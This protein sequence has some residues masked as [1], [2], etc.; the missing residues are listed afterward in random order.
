MSLPPPQADRNT[1]DRL[2]SVALKKETGFI[3]LLSRV[4]REQG[5]TESDLFRLNGERT[6]LRRN[7]V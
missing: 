3:D 5:E 6:G 2:R 4:A 7:S 1:N